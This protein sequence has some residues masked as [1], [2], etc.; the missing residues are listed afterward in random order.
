MIPI[1]FFKTVAIYNLK[2]SAHHVDLKPKRK[3]TFYKIFCVDGISLS[4]RVGI[5]IL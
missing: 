1:A 5:N 3:Q 4:A 2:D